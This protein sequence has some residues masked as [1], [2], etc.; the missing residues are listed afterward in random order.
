MPLYVFSSQMPE[1]K[2]LPAVER[3]EIVRQLTP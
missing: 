3:E 2:H 1:L